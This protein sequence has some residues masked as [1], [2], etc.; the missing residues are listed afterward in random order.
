M[1]KTSINYAKAINM[2]NE[3]AEVSY[4][5]SEA[6]VS[7]PERMDR[8]A[9]KGLQYHNGGHVL[10]V[11]AAVCNWSPYGVAETRLMLAALYHDIGF[12]D[13]LDGQRHE[14]ISVEKFLAEAGVFYPDV[15]TVTEKEFV[16]SCI[17]GTKFGMALTEPQRIMADADLSYM[18]L[19]VPDVM[20]RSEALREEVNAYHH[21]STFLLVHARTDMGWLTLQRSFLAGFMGFKSRAAMRFDADVRQAG[22]EVVESL[23]KKYG[24]TGELEKWRTENTL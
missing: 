13:S 7:L 16:C 6:F 2:I 10:E 21:G 15:L 24:L 5:V 4:L 12:E 22:A 3:S 17:M 23:A 20:L 1:N 18:T 8:I 14:E 9:G 19:P 11:C